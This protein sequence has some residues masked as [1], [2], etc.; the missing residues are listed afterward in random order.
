MGCSG[1]CHSYYFGLVS[2]MRVFDRKMIKVSIAYFILISM[3]NSLLE[4]CTFKSNPK[5]M[6]FT[7]IRKESTA[8]I[9]N[10]F[11]NKIYE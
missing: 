8:I 3:I 2:E 5:D 1:E 4:Q 7:I 11:C 9:G 10:R 6:D